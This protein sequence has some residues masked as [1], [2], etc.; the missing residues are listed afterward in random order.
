[1]K[2][3]ANSSILCISISFIIFLLCKLIVSTAKH[4]TF[5][6]DGFTFDLQSLRYSFMNTCKSFPYR[7][8]SILAFTLLRF[9]G[10]I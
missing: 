6:V 8:F 10:G 9:T 1:M 3:I 5:S 2:T 7:F 4:G